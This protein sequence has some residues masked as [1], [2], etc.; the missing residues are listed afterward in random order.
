MCYGLWVSEPMLE[1][2]AAPKFHTLRVH[3]SRHIY[4]HNDYDNRADSGSSCSFEQAAAETGGTASF[5][6]EEVR[7]GM[8]LGA[9]PLLLPRLRLLF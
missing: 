6:L 2:L 1:V 9:L 5:T 7:C 4:D 3:L 8:T